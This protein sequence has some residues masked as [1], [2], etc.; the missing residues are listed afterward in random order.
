M[1]LLRQA[2]GT[3]WRLQLMR[4]S[5]GSDA[6]ELQEGDGNWSAELM[7]CYCH[8][9]CG[10]AAWPRGLCAEACEFHARWEPCIP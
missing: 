8:P 6:A 1:T 10:H 5:L 4:S 9:L 2:E 3:A 7:R